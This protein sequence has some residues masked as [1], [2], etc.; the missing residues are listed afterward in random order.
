MSKLI[1]Q[2][3]CVTCRKENERTPQQSPFQQKYQI[4]HLFYLRSSR[5]QSLEFDNCL[6]QVPN[7][8]DPFREIVA[9]L[10]DEGS[11]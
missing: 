6:S 3:Y 11:V 8:F 1:G 10:D 7:S 5:N 9:I 2:D 4:Y